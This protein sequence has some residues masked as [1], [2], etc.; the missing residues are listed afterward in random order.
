[1]G[2]LPVAQGGVPA[3]GTT[4]QSPVKNSNADYDVSWGSVTPTGN[5]LT[6]VN[7]T[8]VTVTLTGTPATALLQAVT[9]TFGWSG[10]LAISRGGTGAA[11]SAAHTFFANNTGS[12]GAPSFTSF[13]A[14]TDYW[15]T[16]DFIGTESI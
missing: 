14:G 13:V 7:D 6:R 3:G 16:T 11:T 4:G 8:N 10:T 15:D 2:A 1:M 9:I 12:S 5:A